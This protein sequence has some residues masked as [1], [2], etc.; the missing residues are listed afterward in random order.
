MNRRNQKIEKYLKGLKQ[1][2]LVLDLLIRHRPSVIL[3]LRSKRS[4]QRLVRRYAEWMLGLDDPSDVFEIGLERLA[5]EFARA[6]AAR[7]QATLADMIDGW[8]EEES[9]TS[10][11]FPK[12]LG[13]FVAEYIG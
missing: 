13:F 7:R 11:A 1:E 10:A 9:G 4:V 2:A 3:D 8:C 12:L 6:E 5:Y